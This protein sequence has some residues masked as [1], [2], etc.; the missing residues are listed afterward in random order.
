MKFTFQGPQNK[1]F[2]QGGPLGYPPFHTCPQLA[3]TFPSVS[4]VIFLY[5]TDYMYFMDNY[6][7]I[8]MFMPLSE[9]WVIKNQGELYLKQIK[10]KSFLSLAQFWHTQ[11]RLCMN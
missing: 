11:E 10:R 2:P 3:S 6:A 5:K 8:L 1:H 4:T 9:K 7:V